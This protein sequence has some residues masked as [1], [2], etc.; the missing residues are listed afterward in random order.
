MDKDI[1]KILVS[2]EQIEEICIRLGKQID[3]DYKGKKPLLLGLLRG[4]VP[5]IGDLMKHINEYMD[6]DFM[7]VS[8]YHGGTE[9]TGD[10][11]ILKDL[12]SSVDGRHV[13]IA[14]DI[15][16]TGRTIK[17][18]IKLLKYRNAASVEVVTLLDKPE[19]RVVDLK[20]KYIGVTIPKEFV[21]GYGLDYEQLYRNL[22]YV[23][24]LKEEVYTK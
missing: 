5:F 18:V 17:K 2:K 21:V 10:V 12:D 20:P 4:C 14:E 19:G 24:V 9:S 1:K 11:K 16:D 22:P 13:I 15:V 7:D 3:E 6:I 23:G 8:S